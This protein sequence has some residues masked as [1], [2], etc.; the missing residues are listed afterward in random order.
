ML[1]APYF[2]SYFFGS[3]L[4]VLKSEIIQLRLHRDLENTID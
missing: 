1:E 3:W 2:I 4:P